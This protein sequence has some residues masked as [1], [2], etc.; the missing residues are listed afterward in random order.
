MT[1]ELDRKVAKWDYVIS[2][3]TTSGAYKT[4]RYALN[5]YDVT[6]FIIESIYLPLQIE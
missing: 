2:D 1:D 6:F 5:N 4:E 3:P